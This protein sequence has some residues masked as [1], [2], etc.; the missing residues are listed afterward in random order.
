[1][2][3]GRRDGRQHDSETSFSVGV[4]VATTFGLVEAGFTVIS[5][6]Y[7]IHP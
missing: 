4:S 3:E 7:N 2:D 1:L 6:S 5:Y